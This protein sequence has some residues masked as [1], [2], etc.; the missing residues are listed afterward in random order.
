MKL[1]SLDTA[2]DAIQSGMRIWV[3]GM[4]STPHQLLE[5]L[6][7]RCQTL[8]DVTLLHLHLEGETPWVKPD[9]V[10]RVRDISLFVGP[11][12]RDAVNAGL[13]DYLPIF[14]S[15]VPLFLEDSEFR[16]DVA[17]INV[18]PPD[19]HGF[20]S[21]GPTIEATLK[22]I[23]VAPLTIAQ[24]NPKVPRV[25]G[26]A[27]IHMDSITYGVEVDEALNANP[28][29]APDPLSLTIGRQVAALI[30]D[31]AVLQLGIGRIPDAVLSQ[32]THHRDLGIHS[33]M[34]SDGVRLLAEQGVISGRYKG[35]DPGFIVAT[36]AMGSD[37]LYQFLDDNPGV[38]M[39]PVDYTN[40]TSVIR[41]NPRMI[42]INS[43]I[44]V[45][46]T[47]QV[48]AESI[49]PRIVSGVGG[50]MDFVRGA[51][52]APG[53]RSII[54][55]PSRTRAGRP[56]IVADIQ[57]G[58]A[59]TTTRNHVQYVV[60]EYGVAELH[61]RTLAQRAHQLIAVAH[62]D[63]REELARYAKTRLPRF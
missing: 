20:V 21:L 13:S 6:A 35:T 38:L 14:L 42:S 4:A 3:Q 10:D 54:A 62:P 44:E 1:V 45:D 5:G 37:A 53:G 12:L 55:L 17:L 24:V 15:E 52:L 51:S 7:E 61:G 30:P 48:V 36:F 50:Q 41:R 56:R 57:A 26:D 31:R 32:L 46:L 43:A 33:E 34:I 60:T 59:V 11:N 18:S 47:G 39:R 63:D 28:V 23:Q 2:L 40:N 49:G 27:Q 19:R 22:A 8:Q 16:P 25:L 9:L 29:L 58:A